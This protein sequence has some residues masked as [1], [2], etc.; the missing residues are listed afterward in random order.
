M[1]PVRG[2]D[3]RSYAR[4]IA[5][6]LGVDLHTVEISFED[7]LYDFPISRDAPVPGMGVLH[8]AVDQAMSKAGVLHGANSYFS[9][10]G[11]D[12][13]FCYLK[14]ASPAADAFLERGIVSGFGAVRDLA[15]LHDCTL[16]KAGR[17]TLRKLRR[18]AKAS[19]KADTTFL[20]ADALA[21]EPENHP[22]L[23]SPSDALPGDC[24]KIF[25]LTGTQSYRD[26]MMRTE[27]RPM[28]F[29]LLSQPVMQACLKVPTW[30]WIAGG[31][32]RAVARAAF[33]DRLPVD[34]YP[35]PKKQ[36]HLHYLLWRPL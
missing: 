9:G 6:Y 2:T 25:G 32:N 10:G 19:Y 34:I 28:R 1:A 27:H 35:V 18:G 30:M 3:E 11:G 12:S 5:S 29:P 31:M 14:T 21:N 16:W 4:K 24:E 8:Y 23:D 15:S 22:W 7:A 20:H 33:A 26:G 13:I 36:R 17:L